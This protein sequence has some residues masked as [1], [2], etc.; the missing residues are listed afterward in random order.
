MA[1]QFPDI[2]R[3]R[4][5]GRGNSELSDITDA[6]KEG[7]KRR[8][9]ER[10]HNVL[11]GGE[12]VDNRNFLKKSI[13]KAKGIEF[14]LMDQEG[15][16]RTI[17]KHDPNMWLKINKRQMELEKAGAE[18]KDALGED[19]L[20]IINRLQEVGAGPERDQAAANAIMGLKEKYPDFADKIELDKDKDGVVSD[21]ELSQARQQLMSYQE[22]KKEQ[23]ETMY[24]SK[25]NIIGQMNPETGK[26]EK[27]P[28]AQEAKSKEGKLAEDLRNGLITQE[29]YDIAKGDDRKNSK[30]C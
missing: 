11:G 25:G 5:S 24:D 13:D 19:S 26:I 10:A 4:D 2:V 3:R 9:L 27:D 16:M 28:R 29:E 21:D 6:Y 7:N 18:A 23:Y 8:A 12:D 30:R 14:E 17:R 1:L 15:A 22:K 20:N